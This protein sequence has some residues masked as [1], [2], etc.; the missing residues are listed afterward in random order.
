MAMTE[1]ERAAKVVEAL[2]ARD[3]DRYGSARLRWHDGYETFP[4]IDLDLKAVVLNP[5]SHRIQA[6][7]ESHPQGE[8]VRSEPFSDEAQEI[9]AT[10]LKEQVEGYDAL[11]KNLEEETQLNHGVV[12]PTGVLVN[13]NRRTVALREIGAHYIRVAALP[14]SNN[15]EIADLE[16]NLQ[17]QVDFRQDYSFTNRLLFVDEL[18]TNEGRQ[19]DEV[20]RALNVAAST[21]PTE[22]ERGRNKVNQDTRVLSMIRELQ[23]RSDGN[24]PLTAFDSQEVAFEELDDKY[25][26]LVETDPEGAKRLR[27]A[28]LL[29]ILANVP[30][31]D[32]R[33]FGPDSPDGYVIPV[34]EEDEL[35]AEVLSG[36][37]P[38]TG[39][40]DGEEPGGLDILEGDTEGD[41][42]AETNATKK[43][44][45][46]VELLARSYATVEVDLPV[47]EGER[48]EPR[49]DVVEGL[50]SILR[51]VAN[52]MADDRRADNRIE[53]PRIRAEEADRKLRLAADAYER[54]KD[55]AD[56]DPDQLREVLVTLQERLEEFIEALSDAG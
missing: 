48:S 31:R 49:K 39:A 22:M 44:A 20:A 24:L 53:R 1:D 40:A 10:I 50:R 37:N 29:G 17:M 34:L 30:Y 11:R 38:P 23:G 5:N 54:V 55:Q 45:G 46:L 52:E 12:T 41:A 19:I 26:D 47:S 33:E 8:V 25:E 15:V 56:F 43:V 27:E 13:A 21:N 28:R 36:I 35:F 18:I 4:I 7:L 6:Q 14:T 2:E 51:G 3:P 32:L 16:L 42:G 9:I